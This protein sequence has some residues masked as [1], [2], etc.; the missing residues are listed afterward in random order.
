M[1]R[2]VLYTRLSK[3]EHWPT[4]AYYFPLIPFFIIRAI[5][6]GHIAHFITTN[7]G[8][9]YSGCGTESKFETLKL[10]P[11]EYRP[12]GILVLKTDSIETKMELFNKTN[13][14]YPVIAK[15]DIGFRGYLVKK[16]DTKND[17]INYFTHVDEDIIVQEFIPYTNELGV[18]YYRIPGEKKGKI[19]SIT[20][21]KF[22]SVVGDGKST[23]FELINKDKRAFL[24]VD[25]FKIIHKERMNL[26]YDKG[27]EI[28]LTFIGNHSK[29]TQF[30]NGSHLISKELEDF[31]DE[32]GNRIDG[33]Y[34]GRLDIK[35]K[36]FE[37]LL[38][39]EDFK[40]LEV[41]GI[42]SE[43]THIYDASDKNASFIKAVK[44]L[45]EH[46]KI[47]GKIAMIN[48]KKNGIEYP[49]LIPFFKNIIWLKRY[50]RKL[51]KLNKVEF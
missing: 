48:N 41:N 32:I 21:K 49:K 20:D 47:M 18:F 22:I 9:L 12:Q 45:N 19:T 29:G 42:I 17:L 10:V 15:P 6:A 46:W 38:K 30:L 8:I 23:L 11:E 3:W 50:S 16:I 7:P 25:L 39:K 13:L 1:R 2:K 5:K 34:Y 37:K 33:W 27:H 51:K 36:N 26:I 40:I 28:T 4:M 44:T 31:I 14:D 24:Y 43:P 35:F